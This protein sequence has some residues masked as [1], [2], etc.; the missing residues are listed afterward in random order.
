MQGWPVPFV[1]KQKIEV[2]LKRL[3]EEGIL[4]KVKFS[5]L[6]TPTVP[7]FKPNVAVRIWGKVHHR[8]SPTADRKEPHPYLASVT[9]FLSWRWGR[10]MFTKIDFRQAYHQMG[11]EEELQ[12]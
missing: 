7:V 1:M 6:S 5:N 9:Y 4:P 11:V 12:E 3:E 10:K 8:K 2:E